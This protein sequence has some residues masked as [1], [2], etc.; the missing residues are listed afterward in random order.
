MKSFNNEIVIERNE[1]FTMNKVLFNKDGSPYI[2]PDISDLYYLITISNSRYAQSNRYLYRKWLNLDNALK[3]KYTTPVNI[4]NLTLNTS[5]HTGGNFTNITTRVII[6][7]DDTN[8][9]IGTDG[10]TF[11]DI[12]CVYYQIV[13]GEK[14]YK[15]ATVD[16]GNVGSIT[17]NN[18][19]APIISTT[20]SSELTS[21]FIEQ[22]YY[23]SIQL[24]SGTKMVEYL[25]SLCI[26]YNITYGPYPNGTD[27]E[28][29]LYIK[30][31]YNELLEAGVKFPENFDYNMIVAVPFATCK[32]ILNPT[33]MTVTSNL[34]GG[35]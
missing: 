7:G 31:L 19:Y 14:V 22:V 18:Y 8:Y 23:Y 11:Y 26:M 34:N 27:E 17:W 5:G 4:A 33:K 35:L 32:P 29:E 20:F 15:Y 28:N 21:Q 9:Y 3:F 13:D 12:D 30:N 16:N 10:T 25:Q 1:T 24:V 2:L 6:P